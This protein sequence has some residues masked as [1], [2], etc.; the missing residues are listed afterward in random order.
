MHVSRH[1]VHSFTRHFTC[2]RDNYIHVIHHAIT[3]LLYAFI[4]DGIYA[5][6]LCFECVCEN[7][8][9]LLL[10]YKNQKRE[11]KVCV[12]C[13]MKILP[14]FIYSIYTHV[15]AHIE[16]GKSRICSLI[17]NGFVCV[18]SYEIQPLSV[19]STLIKKNNT[20]THTRFSYTQPLTYIIISSSIPYIV[21]C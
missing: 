6:K 3:L 1:R 20:H 19:R 14:H 17:S 12:Q 11:I 21:Y 4:H 5:R 2:E 16:L 9:S 7:C 8:L 18:H 15:H 10:S 13:T